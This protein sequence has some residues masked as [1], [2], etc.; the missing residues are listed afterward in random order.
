M[1]KFLYENAPKLKENETDRQVVATVEAWKYTDFLFKD[2]I[3]NKLENT[4]YSVFSSIKTAEELWDSLDKKYNTEDA[5]TKRF[6]VG[7]TG[8][9]SAL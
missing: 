6:I 7:I 4:L 8:Q 2:Y 1:A 9:T 5:E 3:L